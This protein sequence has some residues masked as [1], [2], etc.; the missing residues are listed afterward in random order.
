MVS[1]KA[2]FNGGVVHFH[3]ESGCFF[4]EAYSLQPV[5]QRR[6]CRRILGSTAKASKKGLGRTGSEACPSQIVFFIV[7]FYVLMMIFYVF[8]MA[9]RGHSSRLSRFFHK[10]QPPDSQDTARYSNHVPRYFA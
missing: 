6:W 2:A 4:P 1:W 10:K 5:R 9:L 3:G 7:F 8:L